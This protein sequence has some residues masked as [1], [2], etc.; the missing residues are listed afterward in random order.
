MG[1]SP[2][3][4]FLEKRPTLK[5]V[6]QMLVFAIRLRNAKESW[7]EVQVLQRQLQMAKLK[8]D[9]LAAQEQKAQRAGGRGSPG[10]GRR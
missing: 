8:Q 6:G 2:D 4:R 10:R 3:R 5:A 9:Q 7:A 1:I